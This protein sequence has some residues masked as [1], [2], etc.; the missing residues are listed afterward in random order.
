VVAD[1]AVRRALI[2][3]PLEGATDV[4]F[5]ARH[6][7]RDGH[8]YAN[9][10]Y[11]ARSTDRKAYG[12]G[13][14]GLYRLD[15]RTGQATALVDA[16][17]GAVRD[18][19]VHYDGRR[20]VFA[21]RKEGTDHYNLYEVRADGTALRQIT[22]GPWDDI[23]PCWLPDGDLVFCSSRCKRWVNCWLTQVAVLYRCRADGSGL[24]PLS[25]NAE[26]D[27]TPWVLPDGRLLHMRWE[28]VDRS[29]VDYHHLWTMNPDGTGQMVYFGN[30]H[31]G[32]VMIDAKP[33]PGTDRVLATFSGGHGAREHQGPFVV[34]DPNGGPD[35]RARVA[36]VPGGS[37]RD[38]YPLAGGAVLFAGGRSVVLLD[39]AR[40]HV[41]YT[42]PSLEVHE[43]RPLR[44]R[45]REPVIAPSA[46]PA[47][48]TGR[49]VLA[50]V[51]VGRNMDG[52]A[53]GD[54]RRL[55]VLE[56][57]PKPIN[58]TGGMDPLSYGGT[59]TL[60]RVLGTVPVEADGSAYLELPAL[61]SFFF[62]ALDSSGNSVKR[63]QSFLAVQPGE[64]MGC[65]GCHEPRTRTVTPPAGLLALRRP[66]SRPEPVPGVPDVL[67]FPRDVQPVLDRRCLAC[68]DYDRRPGSPHGPRAGGVILSGDR[69]PMFSHSYY[70][71]TLRQQVADGR[72]EPRGNRPPRSIGTAASPLMKKLG[73]AH[74]G[75]RLSELES[76]MIR[77]WI[78]S[79][80]AYPGTY[81]ALGT[82]MI[83]GYDENRPVETD[84]AWPETKAAAEAIARRCATCHKGPLQ[85]PRAL[86]D[87]NGLSFW[88]PNW[89]DARLGRSRHI[90]FNL[91][92]P[93]KSLM[94]LAPLAKE[95]GG[96]GR[97]AARDAD[98]PADP[99]FRDTTDPDYEK[100]LA[101]IAAGGRRLEEIKRFDMPGFRPDPAYVREMKRYGVLGPE[102]GAAALD[103]YAT[104]QAYWRSLGW[105]P[106]PPR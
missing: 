69:G 65:V 78:E 106:A 45:P 42:D 28:Y 46:A 95:A 63:M 30:L 76:N 62:V 31:P 39:A 68:H 64:T 44:P 55:L 22:D 56:A 20:I 97:C 58:Y 99:V 101:M 66:P 86:A 37:G 88:R 93:E 25:A 77:Y 87:E 91:T 32:T 98:G 90:V 89:G 19:A 60:E 4:I 67:D 47:K 81:A 74:H 49:L 100:V 26:H 36:R 10:A 1:E 40:P 33:V 84:G 18:P 48:D 7:G 27:N 53:P 82:G 35:E 57:L 102:A 13:G 11:Y 73:G 24:R 92:R 17:D 38:P 41:L 80:A 6:G 29:Q 59:F 105:P 54:V 61:R 8:W 72:N 5:A 14:G 43:P 2:A 70:T 34:V 15:L 3:G 83:G 79:G 71:L 52:V 51:R 103:V 85:L 23:E 96:Y 9:F 16:G 104:D 12:A 94:L 75:V 50:D 21:W